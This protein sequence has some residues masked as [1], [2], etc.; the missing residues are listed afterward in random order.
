MAFCWFIRSI[1]DFRINIC[2]SPF[3]FRTP[4]RIIRIT[5][6]WQGQNTRKNNV[7][8]QHAF[9]RELHRPTVINHWLFLLTSLDF[10]PVF[11]NTWT[12][13]NRSVETPFHKT[14]FCTSYL[15]QTKS[16]ISLQ[17]ITTKHWMIPRPK[18]PLL[19]LCHVLKFVS[20]SWPSFFRT[21][22]SDLLFFFN[23]TSA[24]TWCA[25]WLIGENGS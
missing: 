5:A 2:I 1:T 15:S 23:K 11:C 10:Q 19:V 13:G 22:C 4:Y 16:C 21:L 9:V 24:F 17:K 7:W 8:D 3:L 20:F 25:V 6:V 14:W 18:F 12:F